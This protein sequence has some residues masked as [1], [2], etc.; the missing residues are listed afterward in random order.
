MRYPDEDTQEAVRFSREV[1][2]GMKD[3][4]LISKKVI[5]TIVR[6]YYSIQLRYV[7]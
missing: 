6:V 5:V 4:G 2:T 7:K 1:C 3:L